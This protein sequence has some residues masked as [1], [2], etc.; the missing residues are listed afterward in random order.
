MIPDT[1]FSVDHFT[2][3]EKGGAGEVAK[4]LCSYQLQHQIQSRL[5]TVARA[6]ALSIARQHPKIFFDSL[7]DFYEVR[8]DY[9]NPLFSLFRE[10]PGAKE[11][12][13][14]QIADILHLHWTPGSI[15]FD[16]MD[17]LPHNLPIVWTLHDMWPFTG[18]CHHSVDCYE[19]ETL[20]ASCPQVKK[21]YQSSVS[22]ALLKKKAVFHKLN[23]LVLVCPS[24]WIANLATRST[25]LKN[26]ELQVIRNPISDEFFN[27]Y[28][29]R[30][31]RNQLTIDEDALVIACV[32]SNLA[33]SQKGVEQ[34]LGVV[35]ELT[36]TYAN[37]N[38][39]VLIIGGGRHIK[40]FNN[41]R[42]LQPG[43]I[44]DKASLAGYMSTADLF[45][46]LSKFENAPLVLAESLSLGVPIAANDVGGCREFVNNENNGWLLQNS[47]DLYQLIAS[48]VENPESRSS[49]SAAAK[50]FATENFSPTATSEKYV[51]LY[52]SMLAK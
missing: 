5:H 44:T 49:K 37:A 27:T 19:F 24:N 26:C 33:D 38:I 6:G 39:T 52:E 10:S 2:F 41:I 48:L 8:N 13:G 16:E 15:S 25:A 18:G 35:S 50:R 46:S 11:Q 40:K 1:R 14:E 47:N 51:S 17:Q 23:N 12:G 31:W 30:F 21:R 28:D 9:K 20:C 32:A 36:N 22:Q 3:S 43:F 45:V 42:I 29:K 4:L 7:R 34:L